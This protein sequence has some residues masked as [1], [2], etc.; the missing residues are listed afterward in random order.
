MPICSCLGQTADLKDPA[1]SSG[2][3]NSDLF[4]LV[5]AN[6]KRVDADLNLYERVERV[7]YRKTG[8]DPKPSD[9]KVWQVF[10]A[11]TG[12][13]KI[14]LGLDGK[15][16][17]TESYV[18]A[19]RKL[20]E[21]LKWAAQDGV[22]QQEAYSRLERR[23]KER[24]ALIDATR[25]A[26]FFTR[27]GEEMRDG[28][29][30]VKYDMNRNPAFKP[31]TRNEMLF[32]KVHG[33]IW[34]DKQSSELAKIE[35]EVTEDISIALFL[36]KVYR[37]SY[38]MQERYEMAPGVWLPSYQQYDFDG[39]KFLIPFS[40]HERTFYSHYQRVGPPQQAMNVVRDELNK[41]NGSSESK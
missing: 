31:T 13:D 12:M 19:L 35:G 7:E 34:I 17:N 16:A 14:P 6:Q 41:L 37:G 2:P 29:V 8:S 39:R 36:A 40:I 11:G 5:I 18:E 22:A 26:F 21:T 25:T 33:T 20:E 1:G 23:H 27:V 15:P 38:F 10:P 9:V 30:L 24:N 4:N 3:S 32:T 28:R